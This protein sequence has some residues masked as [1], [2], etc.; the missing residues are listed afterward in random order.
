MSDAL[1]GHEFN[2]Q[3][4]RIRIIMVGAVAIIVVIIIQITRL[5]RRFLSKWKKILKQKLATLTDSLVK[6]PETIT[7][8]DI[9]ESPWKN[10]PIK[11]WFLL[12]ERDYLVAIFFLANFSKNNNDDKEYKLAKSI[13]ELPSQ[14]TSFVQLLFL[15]IK[16]TRQIITQ[17]ITKFTLENPFVLNQEKNL[18]DLLLRISWLWVF[19]LILIFFGAIAFI[20]PSYRIFIYLFF[21]Q[22]Y[23]L[24]LIW[25]AMLLADKIVDF[26]IDY[27]LERWAREGQEI[28]PNSNRYTLRANTYS[29]ALTNGTTILFSF[30]GIVLT[31]IVIGINPSFL[32]GA[33]AF[34]AIFA[35]LSRNVLEDMINGVLILA[36]DRYA[37][38]DV[39]DLGGGLSG[40]VEDM[41]LY[42][43]CLRNLDGQLIAIP[44]GKI[45]NVINSTKN[46]SRV[47]FT[48]K[49]SWNS[50]LKKA[51]EIMQQVAEK[52]LSESQWKEMILEP[53]DILGIDELS[54]DG[55]LIHLLIKTQPMQQWLVG[56]EFRLRVK[57]A[58]DEA[59]ISLGVPQR[60]VAVIQSPSP[61]PEN[62]TN[63]LLGEVKDERN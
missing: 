55:I 45:S 52:M 7:T 59:G 43:T 51:L 11:L 20:F 5:L 13:L 14:L 44:N 1:W 36:T 62:N 41:N 53:V 4:P 58:L 17:E 19:S 9:I 23:L 38:G 54:H 12:L 3:Y 2:L 35:Y 57:Q 15:R 10:M 63:Q 32:A 24:P 56:R 33:G 21:N 28:D 37:V 8:K 50:D 40:F 49:I 47:N 46:W 39:I 22:V 61:S 30:L 27:A 18:I 31:V 25:I 29:K 34:A 48:L 60:E 26:F 16:T 6:N 42:T